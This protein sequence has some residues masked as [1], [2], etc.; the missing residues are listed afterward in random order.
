[1]REGLN[2]DVTNKKKY[3][4]V[5]KQKSKAEWP[6]VKKM[7]EKFCLFWHMFLNG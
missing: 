2:I 7:E 4:P 5:I 6:I 3:I 1:M